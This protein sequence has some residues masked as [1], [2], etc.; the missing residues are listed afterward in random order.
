MP[1]NVPEN[2]DVVIHSNESPPTPSY[3]IYAVPGPDQFGCTSRGEAERIARSCAR[4][5]GVNLWFSEG[6]NGYTL[7]ARFRDAARAKRQRTT[8]IDGAIGAAAI[9]SPVRVARG[10]S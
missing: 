7:L 2:G 8:C 1:D 4:R 6:P 9:P 10:A 3:A 5:F